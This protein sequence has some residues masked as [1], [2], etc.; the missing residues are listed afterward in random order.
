MFLQHEPRLTVCSR[1][2]SW[3][4]RRDDRYALPPINTTLHGGVNPLCKYRRTTVQRLRELAERRPRS[5]VLAGTTV[6]S[7]GHLTADA[8]GSVLP[9]HDGKQGD[10][11]CLLAGE[12]AASIPHPPNSHAD[13]PGDGMLWYVQTV[14]VFPSFRL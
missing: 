14:A 1:A 11:L 3:V 10:D 5:E 6:A 8:R 13:T 7:Q 4:C 12:L 9:R 2:A